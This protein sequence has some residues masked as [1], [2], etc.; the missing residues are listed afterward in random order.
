MV[1]GDAAKV[2][3]CYD[4][5]YISMMNNLVHVQLCSVS[6]SGEESGVSLIT[7]RQQAGLAQYLCLENE[8]ARH[9]VIRDV[10]NMIN[11]SQSA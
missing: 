2:Q 6:L 1:A 4:R 7:C 9:R 11:I 10:I 3:V 5:V 8:V